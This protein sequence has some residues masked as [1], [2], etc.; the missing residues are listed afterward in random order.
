MKRMKYFRNT[1]IVLMV[2]LGLNNESKGQSFAWAKHIGGPAFDYVFSISTDASG[3]V[4]TTGRFYDTAD[5]DPGSAT[6]NL[7]SAGANDVFVSKLDASGNFVWAK[8]M[9]GSD[10]DDP[11]GIA[12]DASG[13]VYVTGEFKGTSDFDPGSGTFNLTS[14]GGTDVF[15]AKLDAMGNFVWARQLGGTLDEEGIS[16]TTDAF[17]NV[18]TT[19]NF[20]GTVDFDPGSGTFNLT[21]VGSADA[22]ISKLDASGNFVWAMKIGGKAGA[23]GKSII[24]D[25]SGNVFTLGNF[26][27]TAD[28][29]PG[30][31]VFNLIGAGG[32]EVF[33]LKLDS[34]GS[35]VWATK[36]GGID[37][38][39]ARAFTIDVFGNIYTIG[40]FEG[41][42]DFDPD[43]GT[44]NLTSAGDIDI[45]ISKQD[46]QGGLIWAKQLGGS[47]NDFGAGI[48]TDAMGNV[49]STGSFE[50]TTDLD[51]G[52]GTFNFSS[53]GKYDAYV[54]K[55]DSSGNFVWAKQMGG[56]NDDFGR[57][58][59]I[60]VLGNI[61]TT[62]TFYGTC[63]FDPDSTGVLN[64]TSA[65]TT[66]VY[67]HK[68]GD[69]ISRINEEPGFGL[70][71]LAYPNPNNGRV[72]ISAE[73]ALSD[74]EIVVTDVL[75]KVHYS[76]HFE[77][78]N[79]EQI[80]IEG[81]AGIYFL[82]VYTPG[83]RTVIK[84]IKE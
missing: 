84:L 73:H 46:P 10:V 15:V 78:L 34:T 52:S 4:Y 14:N 80:Y 67:I 30:I 66:D 45:F 57:G 47:K 58:L 22:F 31:G 36:M 79:N 65:G 6:F 63:D 74:V 81:S 13:N 27:D 72:Y 51:P 24:V 26:G 41:T 54:S 44:F 1:I 8:R 50:G 33:L 39:D 61:Y 70:Q 21:S 71:V 7:I 35:F 82:S 49:Y 59:S 77:V 53:N 11:Y 83:K 37:D 12:T 25:D 42:C 9:G 18:Y 68:L 5:F 28:F 38:D 17:G 3:N 48:G 19:G 64:L 40:L 60:D 76:K 55:L 20:R 69:K 43:S 29:D 62:G 23:Y 2:L 75:G 16:L 56:V 32:S